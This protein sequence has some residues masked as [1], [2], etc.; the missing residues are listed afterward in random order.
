[1][2]GTMRPCEF[3]PSPREKTRAFAHA[4]SLVICIA[5]GVLQFLPPVQANAQQP[6]GVSVISIPAVPLIEQQSTGQ[7]VNF[8]LL[9][10]NAESN[11]LVVVAVRLSVFDPS[12]ILIQERQITENGKP[13]AID[14]VGSRDLHANGVADLFQPFFNFSAKLPIHRMHFE[15][16]LNR[17]GRP[18]SPVAL[19]SDRLVQLDVYPRSTKPVSFQLPLCG[20]IL[21]E[22][23]HDYF[24]HHRRQNLAARF[25]QDPR[26]A[27]NPNLFAADLVKI[28]KDGKL[29]SNKANVKEDWFSYG[30]DIFAPA[31]GTVVSSVN[32]IPENEFQGFN[33]K[34]PTKAEQQDP[35]GFGNH[36]LLKHADGRVSWLL[37][38]QPGSVLVK[39][40]E[41]VRAGQAVGKIGFSGDSLFPHLHFNATESSTYPS[42]GVP[43]SFTEIRR[44]PDAAD[45]G[46]DGVPLETGDILESGACRRP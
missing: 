14:V 29:F 30:E 28:D 19:A 38:M 46:G 21:V 35:Q 15:I 32:D 26:S 34:R 1:M 45:V 18:S 4:R 44:V 40:G 43:V 10:T 39:A 12:G 23:G 17:K 36:V 13:A 33:V 5:L 24:S 27:V 9:L 6:S 41:Q 31:D 8:D 16:L 42:Q 7:S 11:A 22:D 3:P 20:H 2:N 37:H 25:L